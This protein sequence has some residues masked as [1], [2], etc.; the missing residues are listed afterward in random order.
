M[1]PLKLYFF[2]FNL[3]NP[4]IVTN[5]TKQNITKPKKKKKRA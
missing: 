5:N 4:H 2:F 1:E 3:W